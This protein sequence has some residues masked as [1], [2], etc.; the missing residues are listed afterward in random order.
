MNPPDHPSGKHAG[1]AINLAGLGRVSLLQAIARNPET[2]LYQTDHEGVVV[3]VFDLECGRPDEISY[4]PYANFQAELHTFEEIQAVE[5]LSPYVPRYFGANIDYERKYAFIAM[6]FLHGQNLRLWAE[7]A[8][9]AGYAA[10]QLDDL[11]QSVVQT[12]SILDLFHRHGLVVLDF[13]P[14]NVIRLADGA[15]R[16]V[17]LGAF[18]TPRHRRD[19]SSFVYAATPDHAEVVIDVS[20]LQAGVPPAVASD[21]FAAG[22][23]LFEMATSNSRLM[24]DPATADEILAQPAMYRFRDSQIQDVWKAFP[25]LRHEL[26]LVQTQLRERRLLFS[27]LWHL[28]KAYVAAK[29]PDWES[30][31]EEQHAQVLLSTGTTFIMEQLPPE[32]SWLAGPIARATTLRSFRVGSIAELVQLLGNPAPDEVVADLAEHNS[33]VRMLAS[34]DL[35]ADCVCRPNTWDVRWNGTAGHWAIAAPAACW[36]LADNAEFVFLRRECEDEEGHVFWRAVD[37]FDADVIS[38]RRQNLSRLRQNHQA[39]I[40]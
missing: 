1:L 2:S 7:D 19:L 17:D 26:P 16:L 6:E 38:G 12:F 27:E 23:A 33:L 35:P 36:G 29:V 25:H 21:V 32:L 15:V 9:H 13:K 22:V 18:F 31:S 34:L 39:W 37:E 28:L 8:A 20:N 3:K 14:D 10:A 5:T 24:I 30:L 4:G 40:L 11:L